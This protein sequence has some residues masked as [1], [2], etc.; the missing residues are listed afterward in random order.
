MSHS[1]RGPSCRVYQLGVVG[2]DLEGKLLVSRCSEES[3]LR[4]TGFQTIP[5]TTRWYTGPLQ[6]WQERQK[7]WMSIHVKTVHVIIVYASS[8]GSPLRFAVAE[9]EVLRY[10]L[11]VGLNGAVVA[12][13]TPASSAGAEEGVMVH[14]GPPKVLTGLGTRQSQRHLTVLGLPLQRLWKSFIYLRS[15]DLSLFCCQEQKNDFFLFF[16]FFHTENPQ[17]WVM[18]WTPNT[19]LYRMKLHEKLKCWT[20]TPMFSFFYAEIASQLNIKAMKKI[21]LTPDF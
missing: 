12:F 3:D 10:Q 13:G 17:F 9:A 11:P 18:R 15:R 8:T 14:T 7:S 20:Q 2:G 19:S 5:P 16:F 6:I 21:M 1:S 4:S